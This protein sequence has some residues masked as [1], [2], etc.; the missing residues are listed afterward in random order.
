M[1]TENLKHVRVRLVGVSNSAKPALVEADCMQ[2]SSSEGERGSNGECASASGEGDGA[3]LR[4]LSIDVLSD[5]LVVNL[6]AFGSDS[7][8]SIA[9]G[10]RKASVSLSILEFLDLRGGD[11][12]DVLDDRPVVRTISAGGLFGSIC[13]LVVVKLFEVDITCEE[14]HVNANLVA[15]LQIASGPTLED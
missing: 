5:R 10:S 11:I 14:S 6:G 4:V 7:G 8:F 3:I 1:M 9:S 15:A 12:L 13:S 2:A